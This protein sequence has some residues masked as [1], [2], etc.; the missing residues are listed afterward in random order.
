MCTGLI[1]VRTRAASAIYET[2]TLPYIERLDPNAIAWVHNILELKKERERM[3]FNDPDTTNGFL[4]NID[5]KW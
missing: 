3:L 1:S 2:V 4:L 5:T